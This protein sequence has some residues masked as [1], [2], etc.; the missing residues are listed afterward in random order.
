VPQQVWAGAA[1]AGGVLGASHERV[2]LLDA[3]GAELGLPQLAVA[4]RYAGLVVGD[5][6]ELDEHAIGVLE[7]DL[8]GADEGVADLDVAER[9]EVR[10]HVGGDER[11]AEEV[12]LAP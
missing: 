11:V 2:L 7:E 4:G 1:E 12:A 10:A 6:G 8:A 5:I 3:A 9:V